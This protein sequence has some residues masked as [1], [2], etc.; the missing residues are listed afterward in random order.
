MVK[1]SVEVRKGA[2]HFDVA[3]QAENIERAVS[4]VGE[5]APKGE[6]RVNFPIDSEG[7]FVTDPAAQARIVGFEQPKKIAA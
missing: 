5:R 6:V 4:L 7:F 2:V 3:V 1:V